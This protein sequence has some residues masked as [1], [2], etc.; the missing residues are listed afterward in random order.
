MSGEIHYDMIRLRYA[1]QIADIVK[2]KV[3]LYSKEVC[4][5]KD[6]LSKINDLIFCLNLILEKELIELSLDGLCN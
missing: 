4:T 3:F 2:E 5:D 6:Q 1:R